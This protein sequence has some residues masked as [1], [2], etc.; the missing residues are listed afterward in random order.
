MG[1]NNIYEELES[2]KSDKEKL[3]Y[4]AKIINYIESLYSN[5]GFNESE[6]NYI[7]NINSVIKTEIDK[8]LNTLVHT[9]MTEIEFI[10]HYNNETRNNNRTSRG[11]RFR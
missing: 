9:F 2:I 1:L 8:T 11:S 10:L 7:N 3:L 5:I 6:V 4:C